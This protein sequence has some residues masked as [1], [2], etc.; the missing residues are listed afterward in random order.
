M[1]RNR[2]SQMVLS[3]LVCQGSPPRASTYSSAQRTKLDSDSLS[4]YRHAHRTSDASSSTP[5]T[6]RY[7]DA[8]DTQ[9]ATLI[10]LTM[11]DFASPFASELAG[12]LGIQM[13]V[14]NGVSP[15]RPRPVPHPRPGREL[16]RLTMLAL[17]IVAKWL[18]A[19]LIDPD[20][21]SL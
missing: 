2:L 15:A 7:A 3:A 18:I 9:G 16:H 13:S 6:A 8:R 5:T 17:V 4:R 12:S 1:G 11:A 10:P 20:H 19:L 21:T 14:V